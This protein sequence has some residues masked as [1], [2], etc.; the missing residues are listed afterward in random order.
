M[1]YPRQKETG[2]KKLIDA[3]PMDVCLQCTILHLHD[4]SSRFFRYLASSNSLTAVGFR[5]EKL[6]AKVD[7]LTSEPFRSLQLSSSAASSAFP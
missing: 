3:D 5:T 6:T 2:R 7:H 4:I 1:L